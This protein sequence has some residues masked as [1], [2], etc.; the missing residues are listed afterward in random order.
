MSLPDFGQ[1]RKDLHHMGKTIDELLSDSP[2][3]SSSSSP[4]PA[5]AAQAA[6]APEAPAPS[7]AV[8][9]APKSDSEPVA[10]KAGDDQP[11]AAETQDDKG[12]D[13]GKKTGDGLP[14]SATPDETADDPKVRAA[15]AKAK[16]ETRK[17]QELERQ[18]KER[19]EKAAAERAALEKRLNDLQAQLAQ[20]PTRPQ[21]NLPGQP[22]APYR[23]GQPRAAV[24][25]PPDPD[26][27][28]GTAIR[29]LGSRFQQEL[30]RRDEQYRR[31]LL[32]VHIVNSRNLA[33]TR[34]PDYEEMENAFA[35][36]MERNPALRQQ[37][38]SQPDP[39][40]FAYEMGKRIKAL[41]EVGPDPLAWKAKQEE[42]WKAREE[43]IRK[44]VEAEVAAR[45]A[46]APQQS[47]APTPAPK[48]AAPAR[49]PAAPPS[50]PPSLAGVTS[51]AP[52]MPQKVF[53]G[54]TPLS[55][56]LG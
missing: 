33:L 45:Y 47:A 46:A 8:P 9:D 18:L 54:P 10:P 36:E 25:P 27:D 52:R 49:A 40:G 4:D 28:P 50:P 12:E 43:E 34:Y 3:P 5:P 21:Q 17:R 14:P 32:E 41:Q 35:D 42:A 38:E 30:A 22:A 39:A 2:S 23:P 51:A 44:Q 31:Q 48:P 29:Y 37:M 56:L 55:K 1:S 7:E 26:A 15:F 20:P 24:R 11:K 16:D 19:D 13:T 53:E 6:G